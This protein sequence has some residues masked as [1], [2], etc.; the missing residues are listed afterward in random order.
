MTAP[1]QLQRVKGMAQEQEGVIKFALDYQA[2]P[3]LPTVTLASLNAWRRILF[4]LQLIGQDPPRYGGLGYGNLSQ[5]LAPEDDIAAAAF[6]ISGTQ[7]GS[8]P[9]LRPDHYS[10]VL[11]CDALHNR[12]VARGPVKP[13]SECLTH[14]TLYSLDTKIQSVMHVHSP[15]I[16]QLAGE[17]GIPLT[18]SAVAYGT[19]AM[20]SEV[21][22]IYPVAACHGVFAMGG[23]QDGVVAFGDS[24]E[25]AGQR[26]VDV[27]ARAFAIIDR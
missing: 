12:V 3:A 20:A 11:A 10:C 17:L 14:G 13:S 8:L 2:A 16:W 7:T 24:V 9:V 22:R 4:L 5:R 6:V 1:E 23:H 21:Q 18:D 27:L 19:P 26:L 25:Q 15:E